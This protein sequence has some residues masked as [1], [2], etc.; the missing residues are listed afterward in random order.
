M[1]EEIKIGDTVEIIDSGGCD[2]GRAGDRAIVVSLE[3]K[4]GGSGRI[5]SSRLIS[6]YS[7]GSLSIR[8]V[9]RHRKIFSEWDN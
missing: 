4:D 3:E 8:M 7:K 9:Y 6:G 5:I 2:V 1:T